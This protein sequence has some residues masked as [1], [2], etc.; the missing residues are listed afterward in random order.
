MTLGNTSTLFKQVDRGCILQHA[1]ATA[2][3]LFVTIPIM[4]YKSIIII[5]GDS[6]VDVKFNQVLRPDTGTCSIDPSLLVHTFRIS[7]VG[8]GCSNP[9]QTITYTYPFIH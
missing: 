7:M 6:T 9:A 3:N 5:V 1:D 8:A 4:V 2:R